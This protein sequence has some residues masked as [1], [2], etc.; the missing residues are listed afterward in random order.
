MGVMQ[1]LTGKDW[2]GGPLV[3]L[4]DSTSSANAGDLV[5]NFCWVRPFVEKFRDRVP[6]SF[7][8]ADSFLALDKLFMNN[9][10]IPTEGGDS[11]QSL[12]CEEAKKV[13][14]LIGTLRALWR[15]S[16][17]GS[18]SLMSG[19][20][21][22]WTHGGK[23][24]GHPRVQELKSFLEQSP[25]RCRAQAGLHRSAVWRLTSTSLILWDVRNVN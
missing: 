13:K 19:L 18:F 21:F 15:S 20:T 8:I 23:N 2:S 14:N 11:K 3:Q 5:V 17:S 24:G 6:S 4:E 9:L 25:T 12:A 7:F 16:A 1:V 22:V 10:L